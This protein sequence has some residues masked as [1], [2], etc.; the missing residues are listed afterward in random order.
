MSWPPTSGTGHLPLACA[1]WCDAKAYCQHVGKRLCHAADAGQF[2]AQAASADE[3][4][5]ACAID[6]NPTGQAE[7]KT[8]MCW[9]ALNNECKQASDGTRGCTLDQC[10]GPYA[11]M[12]CMMS[13]H[14]YVQSDRPAMQSMGWRGETL[15]CT[16]G[17]LAVDEASPEQIDAAS[18]V[19]CA[20]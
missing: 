15:D 3:I 17:S 1:G 12:Q 18:I 16:L 13:T 20:D 19:C 8:C 10:E 4:H 9:S 5:A 6:T 2:D 14:I 11:G 7:G